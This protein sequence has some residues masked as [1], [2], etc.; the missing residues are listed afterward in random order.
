MFK[1]IID[2][3]GNGPDVDEAESLFAWHIA[4]RVD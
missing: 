4:I 1:K 2:Q 3:G